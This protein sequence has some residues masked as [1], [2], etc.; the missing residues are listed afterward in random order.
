MNL[1]VRSSYKIEQVLRSA[2]EVGPI[3]RLSTIRQLGDALIQK[4]LSRQGTDGIKKKTFPGQQAWSPLPTSLDEDGVCTQKK[5]I[6]RTRARGIKTLPS[7]S[8]SSK[9]QTNDRPTS[10]RQSCCSRPFGCP[11]RCISELAFD[12]L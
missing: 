7:T 3:N 9:P 6:A 10:L 1:V 5:S 4:N 11:F 2:A 12:P 8:S